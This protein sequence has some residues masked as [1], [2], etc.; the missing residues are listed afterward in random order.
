[1][2][3]PLAIM[4]ANAVSICVKCHN[5]LSGGS[6]PTDALANFRW[7]GPVPEELK[8]LTWVKEALVARSHLFGRVFQLE[9]RKHGE[10]AYSSIK[11]HIV[12][13]PQNTMRLLDI[14]LT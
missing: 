11:E 3:D 6:L 12:L 1:M 8:D 5:C 7:I 2:I 9:E 13:V 14:L 10:P 4:D